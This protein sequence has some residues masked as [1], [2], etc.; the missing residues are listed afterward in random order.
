MALQGVTLVEMVQSKE[1]SRENRGFA[2]IEFFNS[3][4]A[5]WSKNVLADHYRVSELVRP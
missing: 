2:F 5:Q 3:Q 1:N 4:C